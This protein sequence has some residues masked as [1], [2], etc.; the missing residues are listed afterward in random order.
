MAQAYSEMPN[1]QNKSREEWKGKEQPQKKYGEV[2][3]KEA[4]LSLDKMLR[5]FVCGDNTAARHIFCGL[6]LYLAGPKTKTFRILHTCRSPG[7]SAVL[8]NS[9]GQECKCNI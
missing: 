1:E 5:H 3:G 7:F 2:S 6:H 9:R 8:S 4:Q